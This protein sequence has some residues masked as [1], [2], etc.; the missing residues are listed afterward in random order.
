MRIN[1]DEKYV[2]D[3]IAELL[4]EKFEWQKTFDSLRGDQGKLGRR[5]KLPVDAYFEQH[6]LIVEY[7]EIQHYKP[8][9][10]MDRKLTVS[11]I[12]RGEQRKL[13]DLRKEKWAHESNIDFF[14]VSYLDLDHRSSGKLK[15]TTELDRSTLESLLRAH[16]ERG[17]I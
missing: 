12:S 8:V 1:S 2:L 11:G 10:I 15:R 17:K 6:N 7:R 3:L 16:F 9:T 5:Y 4:N 14:A 13:Y